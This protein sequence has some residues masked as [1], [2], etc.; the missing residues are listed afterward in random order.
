MS[1]KAARRYADAMLQSAIERDILEEVRTDMEMIHQTVT[2][3]RDLVL[4]LKNPVI[5]NDIKRKA[6]MEIF[7][8]RIRP[9][10]SVLINLL[11]DKKREQ[12]L[13]AISKSYLELY[14][15]YKGIINVGVFSA[16]DITDNQKKSLLKSLEEST[17]KKVNMDI[18][19]D[20]SLR[21]GLA[22]RIDDTVI[23]GTVKHKI[24]QLKN[25]FAAN[26][27]K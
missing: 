24:S 11:L 8:D 27:A 22:V 25:Q 18:S 10:S 16:F 6:L 9:E 5:K 14:D 26:A 12:L 2:A 23:D 17:G 7:K 1:T 21:G 15:V 19:I 20:K 13:G 3:S 4:F